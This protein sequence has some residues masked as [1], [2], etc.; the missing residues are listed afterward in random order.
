MS[1]TY[2]R[3]NFDSILAET[4]SRSRIMHISPAKTILRHDGNID[5]ADYIYIYNLPAQFNDFDILCLQKREHLKER[6]KIL[7]LQTYPIMHFQ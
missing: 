5:R 6:R 2:F 4:I 7:L 1:F 3:N